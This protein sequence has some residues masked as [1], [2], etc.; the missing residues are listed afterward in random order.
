MSRR[1]VAMALS[2]GG[3]ASL[4]KRMYFGTL[5]RSNLELLLISPIRKIQHSGESRRIL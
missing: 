4:A 1:E 5:D 3:N 2:Q